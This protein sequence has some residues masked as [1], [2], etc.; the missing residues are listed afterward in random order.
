MVSVLMTT[1]ISL[2]K[3]LCLLNNLNQILNLILTKLSQKLGF[4]FFGK[5]NYIRTETI[6]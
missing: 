4:H 5:V 1:M 6:I 2:Y 3:R